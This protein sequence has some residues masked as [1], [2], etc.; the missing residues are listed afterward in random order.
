MSYYREQLEQWISLV[1]LHVPRA[2]DLGGASNPVKNRIRKNQVHEW[3]YLDTGAE[4][5]KE[6]YIPFDINLP[7]IDQASIQGY[8]LSFFKFD[9]LFCLE[10]FEYV[11]NPVQAI[12]NIY[13]LMTNDSV[14]YISFPA[15]YPVHNPVE[16]DY[17]RYTRAV[18]LKYLESVGF[19]NI[20]I[21]ERKATAGIRELQAFYR[22]EGMHPV[23]HSQLPFDIGYLV[24]CRKLDYSDAIE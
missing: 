15:I 10:V 3:V 18:I 6:S 12:Q 24:K 9:A 21:T 2:V 5:A 16:I 20:Q 11:W 19:D 17:L 1:D 7:L 14:A 8:P 13:D 23:R 22:V 4:E